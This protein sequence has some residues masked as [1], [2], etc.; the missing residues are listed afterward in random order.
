MFLLLFWGRRGA[1]PKAKLSAGP[2]RSAGAALGRRAAPALGR[3]ESPAQAAFGR[4]E[5]PPAALRLRQSPFGALTQAAPPPCPCF[6]GDLKT[7][8]YLVSPLS[9]S[10]LLSWREGLS[11]Y[12]RKAIPTQKHSAINIKRYFIMPSPLFVINYKLYIF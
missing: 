12:A 2:E 7:A 11:V 9:S 8:V 1:L 4:Q 6:L 5:P 10:F 3:A